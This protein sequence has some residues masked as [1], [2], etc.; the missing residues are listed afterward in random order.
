MRP[1]NIE[2]SLYA[3]SEAEAT[4]LQNALREFV[5]GKYNNHVYVRAAALTRLLKRYGNNPLINAYLM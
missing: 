3:D 2:F 5:N 1:Y 4:E